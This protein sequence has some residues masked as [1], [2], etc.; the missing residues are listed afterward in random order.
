MT[1]WWSDNM[2]FPISSIGYIRVRAAV[3]KGLRDKKYHVEFLSKSKA[4][5]LFFIKLLL[6]LKPDQFNTVFTYLII[7]WLS[8]EFW[9]IGTNDG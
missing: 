3:I 8:N 2:S 6:L 9:S 4:S 7:F 1:W 5:R